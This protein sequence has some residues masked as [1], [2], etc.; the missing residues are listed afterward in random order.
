MDNRKNPSIDV[1]NKA[2]Q[3]LKS[4]SSDLRNTSYSVNNLNSASSINSKN[5]TMNLNQANYNRKNYSYENS[6]VNLNKKKFNFINEIPKEDSDYLNNMKNQL[7]TEIE[8]FI[9]DK[10]QAND[11]IKYTKEVIEELS[12]KTEDKQVEKRKFYYLKQKN[13]NTLDLQ[14]D[15]SK[16][17]NEIYKEKLN[18]RKYEI[19]LL[20]VK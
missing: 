17:L 13:T 6:K 16:K 14:I 4:K 9:T 7:K 3:M 19:S 2:K 15:E 1:V 20:I 10:K 12:Q 5:S 11:L 8:N 18:Q